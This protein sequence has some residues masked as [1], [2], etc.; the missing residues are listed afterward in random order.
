MTGCYAATW[1]EILTR[2]FWHSSHEENS[3]RKDFI[4]RY[5]ILI[6]NLNK[7]L[8]KD[9]INI[10]I[11]DRKNG[12]V[13]SSI[14]GYR[15]QEKCSLKFEIKLS[16]KTD[17]K[18]SVIIHCEVKFP[19]WS[20]GMVFICNIDD[21]AVLTNPSIP[22]IAIEWLALPRIREGSVSNL[23]TNIGYADWNCLWFFSVFR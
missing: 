2:V 8:M 20:K 17:Q 16:S 9:T 18:R 22:N 10:N 19:I 3:Q 1:M 11:S 12:I 15:V 6:L 14:T 21:G 4:W 13:A 5:K 23:S 7:T